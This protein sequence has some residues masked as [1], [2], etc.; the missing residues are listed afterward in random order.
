MPDMSTMHNECDIIH[1]CG[2][3]ARVRTWPSGQPGGLRVPELTPE[4]R[5]L[6]VRN[7]LPIYTPKKEI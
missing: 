7:M 2:G 6:S 4:K 1:Q 3:G 5:S